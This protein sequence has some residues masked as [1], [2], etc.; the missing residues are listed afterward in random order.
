MGFLNRL[1][2]RK[3]D[4]TLHWGSLT[5]PTPDVELNPLQFGPLKLGDGFDA[6]AFLGRADQCE[7]IYPNYC[8][9]LYAAE[10]F[11]IDFEDGRF[12]CLVF[13]IGPDAHLPKHPSFNFSKPRIRGGAADGV[14]LTNTTDRATLKQWFG[15][16]DSE[17]IDSEE[18]VISYTSQSVTM[19]FELDGPTGKLK[20]WSIFSNE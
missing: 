5:P 4:P 3:E 2:G 12:A 16:P 20:R 11:Q 19:E 13:F 14:C 18:A 7:W 9:L 8:N 10:G 17:D 6:A 1:F 15:E